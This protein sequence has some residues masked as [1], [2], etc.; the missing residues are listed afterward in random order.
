MGKERLGLNI[1]AGIMLAMMAIFIYLLPAYIAM[2]RKHKKALL[3]YLLNL[4]LGWT[5]LGWAAA[6]VMACLK[7]D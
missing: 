6:F 3:I 4:F 2:R 7:K 1:I 5:I